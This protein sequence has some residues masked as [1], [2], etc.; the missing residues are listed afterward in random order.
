MKVTPNPSIF[1]CFV[2]C[3]LSDSGSMENKEGTF[4]L[5]MSSLVSIFNPSFMLAQTGRRAEANRPCSVTEHIFDIFFSSKGGAYTPSPGT[6]A[7][8]DCF[9]RWNMACDF[10]GRVMRGCEAFNLT[11]GGHLRHGG[12][13]R[14]NVTTLKP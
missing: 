12:Y 2:L 11:S 5:N 6:G 3:F 8:H 13:H 4:S 7:K 10:W 9:D 1:V 14:T